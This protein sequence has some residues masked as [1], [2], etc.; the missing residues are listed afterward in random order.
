M[1]R[2]DRQA[3]RAIRALLATVRPLHDAWTADGPTERAVE[4]VEKG[5]PLSHGEAVM[6]RIA[7][8]LWNGGG[9]A[10]V[11]DVIGVLDLDRTEAV[12]SLVLALKRGTL[13]VDAW[14]EAHGA[15]EV[16]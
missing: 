2:D 13:D 10:K 4:W 3:C 7:F 16:H 14:C 9:G 15:P 1:F 12:C 11:A 5:S 6:L 8:D